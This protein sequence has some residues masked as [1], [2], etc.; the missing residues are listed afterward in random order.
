MEVIVSML[1]VGILLVASVNTVG[2]VYRGWQ[3]SQRIHDRNSLAQ[4]LMAEILQQPYS[5]PD[6]TPLLGGDGDEGS[7]LGLIGG[8]G[9]TTVRAN[10]DDINDYH[11]WSSAPE[12]KDG[13]PLVG[14]ENW[15][16]E[17]SVVYVRRSAPDQTV[18]SSE[19]LKRITV[20]VTDPEGR[21]TLLTALRSAWG[22]LQ[23]S[24]DI[25]TTVQSF[26]ASELQVGAG[27]ALHSGGHL[28]NDLGEP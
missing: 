8:G 28:L 3:A 23:Q 16:R 14:Y 9:S 10:Y 22:M 27:V 4:Q 17:V 15:I 12:L 1:L 18:S 11:G 25:E 13:T 7:L 2:G 20:T 5:D 26:V 21:T 6:T 24:P 19:G